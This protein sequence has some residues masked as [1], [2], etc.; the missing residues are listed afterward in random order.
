MLRFAA[1]L[2]MTTALASSAM[3]LEEPTQSHGDPNMRTSAY[4]ADGRTEIIGTV[5]RITTITFGKDETIYRVLFSNPKEPDWTG[6]DT[7]NGNYKNNLPVFPLKAGTSSMLVITRLPDDTERTYQFKMV[8]RKARDDDDPD[9]TYGLIFT[10]PDD[11]KAAQAKAAADWWARHRE[12]V[13]KARLAVDN[14][15]GKRNWKYEAHGK[16]SDAWLAPTQ[17]SDNGQTTAFKYPGLTRVPAIYAV[18]Q[19]AAQRRDACDDDGKTTS[20]RIAPFVM[21]DD[22]VVVQLTAPAFCVRVG[23]SVLEIINRAYDPKGYD[24]GT[25]TTSPDVV[26]EVKR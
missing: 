13:A 21:Q 8:A 20:E 9:A 17:V 10:Y 3:A 23:G 11:V 26:R 7:K 4:H 25:G 2:L 24:P 18:D 19:E 15:G 6:P 16:K 1:A 12:S 5:K 22:M 14:L